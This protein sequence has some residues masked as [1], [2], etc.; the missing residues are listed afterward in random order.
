MSGSATVTTV[1]STMSMNDPKQT[2][3]KGHHLRISIPSFSP[4]YEAKVTLVR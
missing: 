1:V 3:T 2:A 4:R